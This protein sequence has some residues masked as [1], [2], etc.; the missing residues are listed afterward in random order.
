MSSAPN[1]TIGAPPS[2]FSLQA[3]GG[4][5]RELVDAAR[6][7]TLLAPLLTTEDKQTNNT[8]IDKIVLGGKSFGTDSAAVLATALK[9]TPSLR[10]AD[11]ADCIASRETTEALNTLQVLCDGLAASGAK[12]ESLDLSDNALGVRGIPRIAAAFA[13]QSTLRHLY[14]NNDGLQ[15]EAVTGL[16]ELIMNNF[17]GVENG[18]SELRTFEIGH[19]CLED[20]GFLALIP[21][22][23]KSPHLERLRIATT[24]ARNEKG[25]ALKLARSLLHL[26]K[27]TSLALN[28]N[29]FGSES[30]DV[31]GQ[32]VSQN[33]GLRS[34]NLGDIGV[35]EEGVASVLKATRKIRPNTLELLDLAANE[36]TGSNTFMRHLCKTLKQQSQSIQHLKLEDNEI[37]AKGARKILKALED[38]HNLTYLNLTNTNLGP[39]IVPEL[40]TFLK[41]HP[42]LKEI[43][44]NGNHFTQSQMDDIKAAVTNEEALQT[45]S[46]N[47]EDE[48]EDEDEE[49]SEEEASEEEEEETNENDEEVDALANK[50]AGTTVSQ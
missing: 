48:D 49:S 16:T 38:A 8:H 29:N 46:D 50:I 7:A 37:K 43:H 19:N 1:V 11:F 36:I 33:P 10:H 5:T 30:G 34:L 15:A 26:R 17:G 14:F 40:V 9:S 44:L 47:D 20:A 27:L 42:N 3:H 28:D 45:M 6:A 22:L 41:S 4:A 2:T 25:E 35:E 13:D 18:T 24:R 39:S 31:I 32:I 12:L 21:L 23:T